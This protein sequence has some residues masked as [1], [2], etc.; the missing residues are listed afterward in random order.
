M[1]AETTHNIREPIIHIIAVVTGIIKE[2]A[3]KVPNCSNPVIGLKR[4][5]IEEMILTKK[6]P[7]RAPCIPKKTNIKSKGSKM[8]LFSVSIS[9][10]VLRGSSRA[11]PSRSRNPVKP[12]ES[13]YLT[14]TSSVNFELLLE[15]S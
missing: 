9:S 6:T 11:P 7:T 13:L 5:K 15:V 10:K 1:P 4:V 8:L 2:N 3:W 14:E 12:V